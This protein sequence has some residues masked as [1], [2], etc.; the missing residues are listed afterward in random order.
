MLSTPVSAHPMAQQQPA[1][2]T[3]ADIVRVLRG[4]IFLIGAF[5]LASL[6]VGFIANMFLA[7]GFSRFTATGY[8]QVEPL[9]ANNPLIKGPQ[10]SDATTLLTDLRTQVQLMRSESLFNTVLSNDNS[11]IRKTTWFKGFDGDIKAAKTDLMKQFS[12]SPVPET[13]LISASMTYS[14]PDDCKTIV[15]EIVDEHLRSQQE[16]GRDRGYQR[17]SML[18]TARKKQEAELKRVSQ[19][20]EAIGQQ[21]GDQG[22]P[23]GTRLSTLEVELT[24]TIQRELESRSR[25]ADERAQLDQFLKQIQNNQE[26]PMLLRALEQG[27]ESYKRISEMQAQTDAI[28]AQTQS[29]LGPEAPQVKTLQSQLEEYTNKKETAKKE[30]IARLKVSFEESLRSAAES[31]QAADDILQKR[32]VALKQQLGELSINQSRYLILVERENDIRTAIK[33]LSGD[34]ESAQAMQSSASSANISWSQKPIRP[35]TPS[36]PKLS[37]TLTAA[38]VM[39]LAVA[40]GIAF[41]R[42]LLDTTVRSPRDIT[43]VGDLTLLGM[44]PH[45]E[46]DPQSAGAKL[47][48]VIFE[49]PQSMTAEQLRQVRTRMQYSAHLD[50]NRTILVTSPSPGDGKTTI[51]TNLAA[52]LALVGR[53]ILLVDANFRR[54]EL[55]KIFAL[56]NGQGFSNALQTAS[57]LMSLVKPTQVPNLSVLTTGAKPGNGTEMLESQ[58]LPDFIEEALKHYDHVIFDSGALLF[59]SETLALAPRVD[60]VV[61]VVR[62]RSNT[63]GVLQRVRD[64]LSQNKAHN[65]GVVLN[66]VRAYAGGYYA[67]NIQTYYEYSNNAG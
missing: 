14:V 42:E 10:Y 65:L 48:L 20:K 35:D 23:S 39:G 9:G 59:A 30:G 31:S 58:L 52:G 47:A 63:R 55:H 54:P 60:G 43:R 19:D 41:L 2:M 12:A 16:F 21:L 32:V 64:L 17:Y 5:L 34:I 40:L 15:N 51:A 45:E 1:G 4:N 53:K 11:E 38:L 27:D 44:V 3:G 7:R 8:L 67:K 36:F 57:S 33:E 18:D 50:S 56:D 37:V 28:L 66:D 61:T 6:I 26:P 25:A 49:A 46:D 13:R 24:S 22:A 29:R 62:A